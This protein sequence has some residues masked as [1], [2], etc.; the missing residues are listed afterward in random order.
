[1][2]IGIES[3][4]TVFVAIGFILPPIHEI[5]AAELKVISIR[6]ITTNAG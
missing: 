3:D 2:G 5:D 6:P 1:M 4:E